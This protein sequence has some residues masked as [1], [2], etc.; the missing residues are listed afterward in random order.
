MRRHMRSLVLAL[1]CL[2]AHAAQADGFAIR[3]LAAVADAAKAA[4]GQGFAARAE[5]RRL[6][7][8]CTGCAGAPMLDLLLGRQTDGT[9]ERVRSGQTSVAQLE[10]LCQA[11]SPDCRVSGLA[12]APA[13]G[14]VSSYA[15][16]SGA[17]ATAVILYGGDLLTIRGLAGSRESATR[18]V[19]ALVR[20]V[21]PRIVGR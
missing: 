21:A 7:L 8:V 2:W 16:G 19:E 18:H 17:G 6:T 4:L 11:R 1:P 9:E 3:D 5:T 10:A 12:V 20:A 13:V 14:W 15:A